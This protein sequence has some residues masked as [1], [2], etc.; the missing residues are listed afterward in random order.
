[1]TSTPQHEFRCVLIGHRPVGRSPYLKSWYPISHDGI[2]IVNF[3]RRAASLIQ[4]RH[5]MSCAC[6]WRVDE[7]GI[8]QINLDKN[9]SHLDVSSLNSWIPDESLRVIGS[10][11]MAQ[12]LIANPDCIHFAILGRRDL[13]RR[14]SIEEDS[15]PIQ[16]RVRIDSSDQAEKNISGPLRPE[17]DSDPADASRSIYLAGALGMVEPPTDFMKVLNSG[18]AL[19]DDLT[20]AIQLCFELASV[21]TWGFFTPHVSRRD[22]T[23]LV[24]AIG[25]FLDRNNATSFAHTFGRLAFSAWARTYRHSNDFIIQFEF[26]RDAMSCPSQFTLEMARAGIRSAIERAVR[27][28]L[29]RYKANFPA[30]L[31]KGTSEQALS[32]L[33]RLLT[34]FDDNRDLFRQSKI[35][36][37]VFA[38]DEIA[39]L[40]H[41]HSLTGSP[42][43]S[44]VP[45][46]TDIQDIFASA[47]YTPIYEAQEKEIVSLVLL[48]GQG[49]AFVERLSIVTSWA[50]MNNKPQVV[51]GVGFTHAQIKGLAVAL[52]G[53]TLKADVLS[54]IQTFEYRLPYYSPSS[55]GSA[56]PQV[57]RSLV[58]P[59]LPA[60][61]S[62]DVDQLDTCLRD[63]ASKVVDT[64][65]IQFLTTLV[66]R[67]VSQWQVEADKLIQ[68]GSAPMSGSRFRY[69]YTDVAPDVPADDGTKR[70]KKPTFQAFM[71]AC[72]DEGMVTLSQKCP[73]N[74]TFPS[75]IT[76]NILD[77]DIFQAVDNKDAKIPPPFNGSP[78]WVN[79]VLSPHLRK[80]RTTY[81][82]LHFSESDVQSILHQ[83]IDTSL[84]VGAGVADHVALEFNTV[85]RRRI[86]ILALSL[87][88][89]CII[90]LKN[91]KLV[92]LYEATMGV[93]LDRTANGEDLTEASFKIV[94]RFFNHIRG[95]PLSLW[96][97]SPFHPQYKNLKAPTTRRTTPPTKLE[98]F[99]YHGWC[100]QRKGTWSIYELWQA[101]DDQAVGYARELDS[102]V[103]PLNDE[104]YK[105]H[106]LGFDDGD[107]E[108]S[109]GELHVLVVIVIAGICVLA[110]RSQRYPKPKKTP[111]V[112]FPVGK[113]DQ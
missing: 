99:F 112:L 98:D 83:K 73:E 51:G 82:V 105:R 84:A 107:G 40:A 58:Y 79:D 86:D 64:Q 113:H 60:L 23:R 87:K 16:K 26:G 11:P 14:K 103:A 24:K 43:T 85:D 104:R 6:D 39:R 1:M 41:I 3:C 94:D 22:S 35:V 29:R 63:I 102:P 111:H 71:A 34:Y 50:D 52:H 44:R 110:R 77:K 74:Y 21:S 72:F 76:R 2:T 12:V 47:F 93:T 108:A 8:Y 17:G 7:H 9:D 53:K 49:S 101:A 100:N 56:T 69:S 46:V 28:F 80:S 68:E 37:M 89:L 92:G 61:K 19:F 33:T 15:S 4:G 62:V 95:L 32:P 106:V 54:F 5:D 88:M 91:I 109:L 48:Q 42:S 25:A 65:T 66:G 27:L 97:E 75:K 70:V 10:F 31:L 78:E 38:Y 59:I 57:P 96:T 90:E 81:S 13:K 20:C 45:S 55:S 36:V 67:G 30:D 18:S